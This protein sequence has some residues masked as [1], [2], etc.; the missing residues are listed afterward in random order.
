M[1]LAMEPCPKRQLC[2]HTST[3][4]IPDVLEDDLI[5]V[6]SSINPDHRRTTFFEEDCFQSHTH[7]FILWANYLAT[8]N[9][10]F[11]TQRVPKNVHKF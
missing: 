11:L 3:S 2:K 9:L 6:L 1:T 4:H 10:G 7:D 5:I 8:L